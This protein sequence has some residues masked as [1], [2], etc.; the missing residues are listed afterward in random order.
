MTFSAI[1]CFAL[2]SVGAQPRND[3]VAI[4]GDHLRWFDSAAMEGNCHPEW[5]EICASTLNF[6]RDMRARVSSF[7]HTPK[8]KDDV[9]IQLDGDAIA[10]SA[11][12]RSRRNGSSV[13]FLPA[14]RG[15][16]FHP[17]LRGAV[18][19]AEIQHAPEGGLSI[20]RILEC[21]RPGGIAVSTPGK[22]APVKI[23]KK[24]ALDS[25]AG[26]AI[27][28]IA[29][30]V[31]AV[32]KRNQPSRW[33]DSPRPELRFQYSAEGRLVYFEITEESWVKPRYAKEMLAA[34]RSIAFPA[35]GTLTPVYAI[36][37]GGDG[38]PAYMLI[39]PILF[40]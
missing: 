34:L 12:L 35:K 29:D 38:I 4:W 32:M 25:A 20:F 7:P 18:V 27:R 22:T 10:V 3:S 17:D 6:D 19:R 24:T 31:F 36:D 40:R 23:G 9:E 11:T 30:S 8:R 33:V 21:E 5:A 26:I 16:R 39:K 14:I 2:S 37:F 13:D 1:L 15:L 28:E